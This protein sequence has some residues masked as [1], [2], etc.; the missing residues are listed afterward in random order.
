MS[1]ATLHL[2]ADLTLSHF[3]LTGVCRRKAER[4]RFELGTLGYLAIPT[5]GSSQEVWLVDISELGIGIC[6]EWPLE[7][8]TVLVLKLTTHTN[9][10]ITLRATVV[11]ATKQPFGDWLIG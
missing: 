3:H 8:G 1:A 7:V 6:T 9:G 2:E 5:D 4:F 11:H 10:T